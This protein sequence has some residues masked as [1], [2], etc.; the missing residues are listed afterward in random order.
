VL[1]KTWKENK[2]ELAWEGPFLV[3]LTMETA[4]WTMERGWTHHTWVMKAAPPDQK[5]QWT[6]LSHPGD[7][8]I[9]FKRL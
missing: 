4:V 3:L 6:V 1:I 7:T 2:L 9:T 5:E 8:R